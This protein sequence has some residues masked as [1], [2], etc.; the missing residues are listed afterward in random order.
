MAGQPLECRIT[1]KGRHEA[2]VEVSADPANPAEL[3]QILTA[4]LAGNGWDRGRWGEFEMVA[5][6]AGTSRRMGKVRP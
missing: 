2:T 3:R 1:R 5:F 6:A 4:W